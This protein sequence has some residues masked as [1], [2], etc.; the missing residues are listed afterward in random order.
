METTSVQ[1]NTPD[2]AELLER[3]TIVRLRRFQ[4]LAAIAEESGSQLWRDLARS[5]A[6]SAYR[7]YLLLGLAD[8]ARATAGNTPDDRAA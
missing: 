5:A 8:Q 6:R 1:R 3:F 4:R 7:D 2:S